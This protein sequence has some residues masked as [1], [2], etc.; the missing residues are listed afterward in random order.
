LKKFKGWL[1]RFGPIAFALIVLLILIIFDVKPNALPN[2]TDLLDASINVGAISVGFLVTVVT[3][4]I[5]I[6][7]NPNLKYLSQLTYSEGKSYLIVLIG[8]IKHSI[9]VSFLFAIV[10]TFALMFNDKEISTL[11]TWYFRF[12]GAISALFLCS[13]YRIVKILSLLLSDYLKDNK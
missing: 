5:S 2:T 1:E 9:G 12:W 10:S 7:D 6:K 3:L 4:I 8:Y 13:L 11:Y